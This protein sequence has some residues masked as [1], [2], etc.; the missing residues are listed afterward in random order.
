[1]LLSGVQTFGDSFG[2][3]QR[4]SGDGTTLDFSAVTGSLVFTISG[5][6]VTVS[7]ADTNHADL[8]TYS[9]DG[10]DYAIVGSQGSDDFFV[11]NDGQ[12][13][14]IN[15]AAGDDTI[16]FDSTT[17]VVPTGS[18]TIVTRSN[19]SPYSV[20]GIENFSNAG[21]SIPGFVN[22]NGNFSLQSYVQ[23]VTLDDGTLVTANVQRIGGHDVTA[24]AGLNGGSADQ[25]GL[26][27]NGVDFAEVVVT[28]QAD[29]SRSWTAFKANA[30]SIAITGLPSITASSSDLTVEVNRPAGDGTLI[31]FS[32]QPL[33]VATGPGS[34]KTLDMDGH[35]GSLDRA[36][37]QV[38]LDVAGF[39]HVVGDLSFEKS[40]RTV[41]LSNGQSVVV[42]MLSLGGTDLDAFAGLNGGSSE[43]VGLNLSGVDFGVALMANRANHSQKFTAVSASAQNVGFVGLND[44]AVSGENI[45]V[46]INRSSGASDVVVDF[47][48]SPVTI[49]VGSGTQTLAIDGSLGA[50]TQASGHLSFDVANFLSVEGDF[51][52]RKSESAITLSDQSKLTTDLLTVGATGVTAF[53]GLN[54][55]T[56]DAIG[57]GLSGVEFGL[58]MASQKIANEPDRQW[59]ALKA[60]ADSAGFYG[61]DTFEATGT[62]MKVEITR[63]AVDGTFIDLFADPLTVRTGTDVG[64]TITLDMDS[65][66]GPVTRLEGNV[67][68]NVDGFFQVSGGFHFEKTTGEVTVAQP[69]PAPGSPPTTTEPE[70]VSVD[71]LLIGAS[72]VDAFVGLNGGTAD[73]LG[74]RATDVSFALALNTDMLDHR[75]QW[76]SLSATAGNVSFVGIDGVTVS[77][78]NV[79]VDINHASQGEVLDFSTIPLNVPTGPGES[80]DLTMN[81]ALGELVRAKADMDVNLFDFFSVNGSFEFVKSRGTVKLSDGSTINADLV[82]LGGADVTAFAGIKFEDQDKVGLSLGGANFGLA[83]IV[84][85]ANHAHHFT[86]LQATADSAAFNGLDILNIAASDLQVAVNRGVIVPATPGSTTTTNTIY[87]LNLFAGTIGTLTFSYGGDSETLA[88]TGT[89]GNLVLRQRIALTIANL[90]GIGANN[91]EV[92]GDKTNGFKIEYIGA[93]A[94]HNVEG[95]TVTITAPAASSNV[96]QT[97]SSNAGQTE[98]KYLTITD[99][100]VPTLP[101]TSSVVTTVP[102]QQVETPPTLTKTNTVYDVAIGSGTLGTVTFSFA[103]KSISFTLTGTESD[104]DIRTKIATAVGGLRG[105]GSANVSVTGS[106]PSSFHIELNGQLAGINVTG[107]TVSITPPNATSNVTTAINP[108][109]GLSE[110]QTVTFTTPP[111]PLLT[112]TVVTTNVAKLGTGDVFAIE[113]TTP[114][115]SKQFY[116]LHLGRKTEQLRF[117]NNDVDNNARYLSEGL[118]KLLGTTKDNVSVLFDQTTVGMHRYYI[119][120]KGDLKGQSI[121][122]LSVTNTFEGGGTVRLLAPDAGVSGKYAHYFRNKAGLQVENLSIST[123]VGTSGSPENS[124][125]QRVTINSSAGQTGL[126][127]LTFTN[128]GIAYKTTTMPLNADAS[129]VQAALNKAVA[130]LAG[131]K[132]TVTSTVAGEWYVTFGGSLAGR[133]VQPLKVDAE[134]NSSVG[135]G[136][137]TLTANGQ[138]TGPI[139]FSSD[140][141]TL[142]N[143]IQLALA[144]NSTIGAGNV[145][146]TFEGGSLGPNTNKFHINYINGKATTEVGNLSANGGGLT[147]VQIAAGNR[148]EGKASVAERQTVTLTTAAQ[149]GSFV[150]SVKIG[151]TTYSTAAIDLNANQATINAAL[152]SAFSTLAGANAHVF[153]QTGR[154]FD[155][156]FGGTLA[157]QNINLLN[158]AI[159]PTTAAATINRSQDGSTT[160]TPATPSVVGIGSETQRVT[161]D[162]NGQTGHFSLSFQHNNVRYTTTDLPFDA[163]PSAAEA[164]LNTALSSLSGASLTVTSPANTTGIWDVTFGGSLEGEDVDLLQLKAVAD[165]PETRGTFT[166]EV[167]GEVSAPITDSANYATL[168]AN[169]VAALEPLAAIGSG[170]V[171]VSFVDSLSSETARVFRVNFLNARALE[172]IPDFTADSS[173]LI[174]ASVRPTRQQHGAAPTAE[175]QRVALITKATNGSFTLGLTYNGT[176]YT[177]DRLP[178]GAEEIAINAALAA[179]FTSLAGADVHVGQW[180]RNSFSV[181]FG[182]SLAGQDVGNLDVTVTA[183]TV[184]PELTQAQTGETVTSAGD[185]EKLLVVDYAAQPLVVP[186]GGTPIMLTMNGADGE[187]TE[188]SGH[189]VI[190]VTQFLTI[191][192]DLAFRRADSQVHV[193]GEVDPV[194]VSLLTIGGKNLTAFAGING[195]TSDAV[196]LTLSGLEFGIAYAQQHIANAPDRKWL[197]AKATAAEAGFVGSNVLQVT[198]TDLT[199]EI[200]RPASADD[201]YLDLANHPI[202]VRTGITDTDKL[203][204][205]LDS[206]HGSVTRVEGTLNVQVGEFFQT[207]GTYHIDRSQAELV[208]SGPV[209]DT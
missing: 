50:V 73:Q 190:T 98:I 40:I 47:A 82:T 151:A 179:A 194:D 43:A 129:S 139:N 197:S 171:S 174:L 166:I 76:T 39:F 42:D 196:G 61:S 46:A 191:E 204:L 124:E 164:A 91:V 101:I 58:V 44:L 203:R 62:N 133:D 75:R 109:A 19:S 199:V 118:A 23:T 157:G 188:A 181:V 86:S 186:T 57:F 96:T 187:L 126:F 66:A 116:Q 37:G 30:G 138:Q 81:G 111:P 5:D 12:L 142:A 2:S 41:T 69:L 146:V 140:S 71:Q 11:V 99:Q 206:S 4:S 192:G 136:T 102:V 167:G 123:R 29:A 31:D 202:D 94:G 6:S 51:A 8:L 127:T 34:S 27:L 93:L 154:T 25:L 110:I 189:L 147:N 148:Q 95:L 172:N 63:P 160:V 103:G 173:D 112:S 159:T 53:A 205:D 141:T 132:L 104:A 185:P 17:G 36:F 14:S 68:L 134:V 107:L 152:T 32:V 178:L 60:T 182:G 49:P 137:F 180:T 21:L 106:K 177:T 20:T 48:A 145:S 120:L 175:E 84:D 108:I 158:V 59:M 115:A 83:L 80:L 28:D 10:Q 79:E 153:S 150:L 161:L 18:A 33:E 121:Q 87:D 77:A 24:F 209:G 170:N 64:S 15:G 195:G 169:I 208:E 198:G 7:Y 165:V 193:L 156:E 55:G 16:R 200:T 45:A 113:F 22:L 163:S 3:L 85:Q 155:V 1:M 130:G 128:G 70:T 184:A 162:G 114:Y 125:T 207:L 143:N 176:T 38:T 9:A 90:T 97:V 183:T 26:S 72:H 56:P 105:I 119:S 88:V 65:S 35:L 135:S 13:E 168:A 201:S 52:I 67:N 54:G 117:V 89:E 78:S 122:G 100:P 131:A 92:T 74:L 144:A 149:T